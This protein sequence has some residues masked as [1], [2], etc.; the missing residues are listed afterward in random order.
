MKITIVPIK[1]LARTPEVGEFWRHTGNETVYQR[2]SHKE[3]CLLR[4]DLGNKIG[5]FYSIC[6]GEALKVVWTFVDNGTIEILKL[7]NIDF[8]EV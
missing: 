4:P 6:F 1:K 2:I 7:V 5:V 8:Q 3:A